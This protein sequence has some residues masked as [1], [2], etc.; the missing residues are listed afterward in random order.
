[1]DTTSN[2]DG[3]SDDDLVLPLAEPLFTLDDSAMPTSQRRLGRP[4]NAL[5]QLFADTLVGR[6]APAVQGGGHQAG[7]HS[8]SSQDQSDIGSFSVY[9]PSIQEL[10]LAAI[11]APGYAPV[12]PV[13]ETI[14]TCHEGKCEAWCSLGPSCLGSCS[15]VH[16]SI[17]MP[18]DLRCG[19][20]GHVQS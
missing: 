11:T 18:C 6:Q 14:T 20:G 1:M 16:H 7:N 8:S 17:N 9:D 12:N 2:D 15:Q 3:D 10:M 4:S 5:R 13:D 19:L